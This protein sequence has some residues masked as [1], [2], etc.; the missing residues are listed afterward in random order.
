MASDV[1]GGTDGCEESKCVITSLRTLKH[2]GN[3][4][5]GIMFSHS[6]ASMRS[7][8]PSN[9]C[10]F[11]S[12]LKSMHPCPSKIKIPLLLAQICDPKN[13]VSSSANNY[14]TKDLEDGRDR[15]GIAKMPA[16][17]LGSV[18][19]PRLAITLLELLCNSLQTFLV[20]LLDLIPVLCPDAGL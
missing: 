7:S 5:D 2:T 10:P 13:A 8:N 15:L 9:Y 4:Y 19:G 12:P 14:D 18:W 11:S 3:C 20:F 16:M 17:S 1:V 6:F